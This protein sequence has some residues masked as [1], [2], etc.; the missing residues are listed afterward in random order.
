MATIV[1]RPGKHKTSYRAVI[2]VKG[3]KP[4]SASFATKTAAKKWA[5]I[6]E[7]EIREGRYFKTAE[8]RKH[9]VTEL[10]DRYCRD[11]LPQKSPKMRAQQE[12]QLHWFKRE[13]G[14][15]ILAQV[16]P[17]RLTECRDKLASEDTHLKRRRSGAACNRYLAAI[18]HA[19]T[20]AS[21]EWGWLDDN[22]LRKVKRKSEPR[23][24]VRYLSEQE[25]EVL[26]QTCKESANPYLYLIVVLAIC[27]GM[28]R[29]EILSLKWDQVD[30]HRARLVLL[31]TKNKERR[32]V[33]LSAFPLELLREQS[34]KRKPAE[35]QVFPGRFE[36]QP[37]NFRKAW[38]QAVEK[39]GLSDFRFHDLRHTAASYLAMGGAS[40]AEIA[41]VLG[42]KTFSMVR[43]YSHLSD[44]HTAKVVANMNER[45]FRSK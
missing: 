40:L 3:G 8:S 6:T 29:G 24:R 43:R 34:A 31:E 32:G 18:S 39:A 9:T 25:R 45:I 42:H 15:L 26:L 21:N 23:G 4:V 37:R 16:T 36:D 11:V 2:R 20:I 27:T 17:Q 30:F 12:Q 5:E 19:F 13:I 1:S 7:R 44:S 33:P 28:R 41:E 38:Y 10:V 35:Q 14:H 22:P